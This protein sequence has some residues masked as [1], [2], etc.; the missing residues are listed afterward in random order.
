MCVPV[1]APAAAPVAAVVV[2]AHP[3]M[4]PA[5]NLRE[6]E[7]EVVKRGKLKSILSYS[8]FPTFLQDQV[9]TVHVRVHV[10]LC[11]CALS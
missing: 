9:H 7:R 8:E 4:D 5:Q 3:V 1:S 2:V 11:T 10:Y 6:E